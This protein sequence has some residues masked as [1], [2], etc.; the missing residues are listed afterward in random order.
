MSLHIGTQIFIPAKKN[1]IDQYWLY[2]NA[3]TW[4]EEAKEM[5]REG[6]YIE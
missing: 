6:T 3:F 4:K 5:D 2:R 1:M